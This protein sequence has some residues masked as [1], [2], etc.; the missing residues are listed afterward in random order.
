MFYVVIY[1]NIFG[2]WGWGE[3]Q[4]VLVCLLLFS[5]R[6]DTKQPIVLYIHVIITD[7]QSDTEPHHKQTD[8]QTGG[9]TDGRMDRHTCTDRYTADDW[10]DKIYYSPIFG[11][12]GHKIHKHGF[13]CMF[14]I[15]IHAL[16]LLFRLIP[17]YLVFRLFL[18]V[19]WIR[20]TVQKLR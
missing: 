18:A 7:R 11:P 2:G 15:N 14:Q 8:R 4:G 17:V 5:L 3:G 20:R 19:Q 10:T 16:A 13:G 1:T 6:S 9:Q 12:W